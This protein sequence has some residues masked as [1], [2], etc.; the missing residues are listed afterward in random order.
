[1]VKRDQRELFIATYGLSHG[2]QFPTMREIAE[3]A[4]TSAGNA[5]MYVRELVSYGKVS[6]KDK[7]YWLSESSWDISERLKALTDVK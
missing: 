5:H 2:G 3:G 6:C 7:K 1:M 4:A